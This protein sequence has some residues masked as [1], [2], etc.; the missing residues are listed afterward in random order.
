MD[1]TAAWVIYLI[2]AVLFMLGYERY[3][4]S[5]L[6]GQREKRIFF[7]AF[8]AILLFTPGVVIHGDMLYIA[9]ACVGIV[10]NILVHNTLGVLQATLPLLAAGFIVFG[11]LALWEIRRKASEWD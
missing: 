8:L 7:R 11:V 9:P 1:Y 10:F 3:I 6:A 4:A 2:M 5:L